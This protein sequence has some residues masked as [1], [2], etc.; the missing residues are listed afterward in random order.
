MVTLKQRFYRP[1]IFPRS[2]SAK[3]PML[4]FLRFLR[5]LKQNGVK[6]SLYRARNLDIPLR[7]SV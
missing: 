6:T 2:S 4:F 7:L 1:F 3:H 5:Q